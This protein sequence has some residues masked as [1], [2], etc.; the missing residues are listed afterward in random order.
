MYIYIYLYVMAPSPFENLLGRRYSQ[1]IFGLR[2]NSDLELTTICPCR[3]LYID[4][5]ITIH[6]HTCRYR[7]TN[8]QMPFFFA[9]YFL[10]WRYSRERL[11]VTIRLDID[12]YIYR[13][14]DLFISVSIC[15]PP[16]HS[17]PPR[18]ALIPRK[19]R[20]LLILM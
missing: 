2:V 12:S 11:D 5:W 19:A 10:E 17:I 1:D 4:S 13:I 9:E 8:D 15:I 20:H 3:S 6:I 7:Y 18:A 16:P 14:G